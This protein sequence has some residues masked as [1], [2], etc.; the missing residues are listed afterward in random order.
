MGKRSIVLCLTCC[1]I[2]GLIFTWPLAQNF[3]SSIPYTLRPLSG[4]EKVPV[5]PGDHLQTY[6]WFWL[7]SDNL[8]GPS[9][10]F[11]N[12][13]EFNGPAGPMSAVYAN[14]PFSILYL[15]LLPLGPIGAY[16][17]LILLSFVL[18]G[19]AVFLLAWTWTKDSWASLLAGLVFAVVP[20]RVSHIA[21][22]QLYGYVIFL[23]PLCLYFVEKT[24]ESGRWVHGGAAGLCLVLMALMEPHTTFLTALT[25]GVYLPGRVLLFRPY[26]VIHLKERPGS[27]TGLLGVLAGGISLALFFW[28]SLSR[29]AGLP[30]RPP[31]LIQPL[32]LW[33]AAAVVIWF[34]LAALMA[35]FSSLSFQAARQTVGKGFFLFT[36]LLFYAFQT[37]KSIPHLGGILLALC[38][39]LFLTVLLRTWMLRRDR[40]PGFNKAAIFITAVGVGIGL[41]FASIYLMHLRAQVFLPSLA[42]KGRSLNEVKLFS[43]LAG[44]LF[45]W[46]D[47]NKERFV[48]LGWGLLILAA[49]SFLRLF[50]GRPQ[51]PERLVLAGSLAFPALILT[52]GPSLTFFPLYQTLYDHLPFFNYPRVP[53]RF[54]MVGFIFLGL[55]AGMALA[56]WREWLGSRG[57]VRMRRWL[58]LLVIPLVLAEYH[59]CGP[60]G[61]SLMR[62]DNR[63]YSEIPKHLPEGRLVLE[64]PIWPG[65]SHQS[66]AYEYTVTR[67]R[68]PMVNGYAPVVFRDYIKEVFWPLYPLDHG[69]LTE[70]ESRELKRL[71]VDLVTFHDDA[72][73]YTEKVSPFPP[74]LTLKRLMASAR[75][76]PLAQDKNITLFKFREAGSEGAA[77]SEITSPVQAVQYVPNQLPATGQ[78]RFDPEASGYT[79]LMDEDSL[80]A[81]RPTLRPGLRGNVVSADPGQ[82]RPGYLF[83]SPIRFFPSGKYQA[84]FRVKARPAAPSQEVGR[85]EL[86]QD[87]ATMLAQRA[88]LGKDFAAADQ[89]TDLSLKFEI[90]KARE[91]GCRV[92]FSGRAPISFNLALIGFADQT[93]GPGSVEAEDLLRQTGMVVSDPLA[94]GQEAVFGKAGFH[95][96]IYL[97]YGP[98]R[99][100]EA[101][102][103]RA[104]FYL[105]LKSIPRIPKEAEVGLLE[106]AADMGKRLFQTRKVRVQDLGSG[107]YRAVDLD[108]K[109]P[110]R[111]ELGFRV[112][113]AGRA[114]L[115]V[116]R[117]SVTNN[118]KGQ[119]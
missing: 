49:L 67:T 63:I 15:I 68:K 21:G 47:I 94:S 62:I 23:L 73:L 4:F 6:Y 24:F 95:P 65:D 81:G 11:T 114:D 106:V 119:E 43:P 61:L 19:L 105:R 41:A 50:M 112:K 91:I 71:K 38:L 37:Y 110:F 58:P 66:S 60:L 102:W 118:N 92:Y 84:W 33:T 36:P 54:V 5:M 46:L 25:L 7:L 111:C 1:L 90:T 13:Y 3:F 76:E 28:M 108:F 89:W 14:F 27:R 115:L 98:Y 80:A 96:P 83:Q 99:T 42:G 34:Y 70:A 85:I 86:W 32:L 69:D 40:F 48:T 29:Q 75:L 77:V 8:W 107:E 31:D 45:F 55:L 56:S 101:G 79:L 17:G 20:Y 74:R 52:P 103:Y 109:V 39:G 78:H 59:T 10:L 57:W 26:P 44:N 97:C 116:D 2:A 16:N 72:L 18:S 100:F 64:L 30:F 117:V 88:L 53:G 113:Y 87:R 35:R 22:G 93:R 12:P 104:R 51:N 9:A 82:D